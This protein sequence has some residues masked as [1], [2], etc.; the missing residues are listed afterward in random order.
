MSEP[1]WIA[2]SFCLSRFFLLSLA[3]HLV[4]ITWG[5]ARVINTLHLRAGCWLHS[6]STVTSACTGL[7]TRKLMS[8]LTEIQPFFVSAKCQHPQRRSQL[9]ISASTLTYIGHVFSVQ[10]GVRCEGG[11]SATVPRSVWAQPD[12]LLSSTS[13]SSVP[14]SR[15]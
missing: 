5:L 15:C 2:Q 14:Q 12:S 4:H 9:I 6:R 10:S 13:H 3:N 11:G 1:L 8:S 7:S